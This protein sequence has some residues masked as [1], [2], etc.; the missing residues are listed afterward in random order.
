[1]ISFVVFDLDSTLIDG[2]AGIHEALGYALGRLGLPAPGIEEVRGMVGEGLERLVEKAAGAENVAEGVRLFR[3]HYA[4]VA[5]EGSRVMPDVPEVLSA[6]AGRGIGMAVAS[7]KPER[8]STLILGAKGLL[9][10]FR[11]V[12]GPAPDIPSKPDP[13]MLLRLMERAGA[14]PSTTLVVGDMEID[15]RFGHAAG[16]PVVLVA[17]GS[18]SAGDLAAVD[19][20]GRID[21]LG[22][23][24]AVLD[25]TTIG[26]S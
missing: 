1:M 12:G 19:A 10:F 6:L 8:F 15:A 24:M 17:T 21:R 5:V 3:E 2:Y 23:L 26:R 20:E 9:P 7:N 4:S 16:C 25:G 11:D 14:H 13:T 18:R 22:G